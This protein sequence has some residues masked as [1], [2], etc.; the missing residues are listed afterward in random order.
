MIMR[1]MKEMETNTTDVRLTYFCRLRVPMVMCRVIMMF[2]SS[3]AVISRPF[4]SG[5]MMAT[6]LPVPAHTHREH[7]RCL[8]DE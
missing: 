6:M 1:M 7:Y 3:K 5:I 8:G 4:G 2:R